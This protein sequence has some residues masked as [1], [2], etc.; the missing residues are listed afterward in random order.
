MDD[1]QYHPKRQPIEPTR[2]RPGSPEK[3]KV[4][5]DRYQRRE[6][7]YHPLDA[8]GPL[9]QLPDAEVL[10]KYITTRKHDNGDGYDYI[11]S[12]KFNGRRV[13]QRFNIDE[14]GKAV[15]L[16]A[17]LLKSRHDELKDEVADWFDIGD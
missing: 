7:L 6:Y 13:W 8:G 4:L 1:L 11:V 12:G 2:A 17:S 14:Y 9:A 5:S 16:V 15:E 3:I 10:P